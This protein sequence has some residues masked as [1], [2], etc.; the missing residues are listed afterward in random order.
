MGGVINSILRHWESQEI[1]GYNFLL[2]M[3]TRPQ[4]HLRKENN[5]I[6]GSLWKV[7]NRVLEILDH[8]K[9]FPIGNR[10]KKIVFNF[11][12]P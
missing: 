3:P 2:V 7:V 9:N 11:I 10:C 4:P 12:K 8:R 1:S 6:M 5:Q